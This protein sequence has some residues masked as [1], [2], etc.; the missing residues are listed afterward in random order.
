ML[1]R[2][3]RWNVDKVMLHGVTPEEAEQVVN[4]A[5]NPYPQSG[6]HGRFLVWGPTAAGRFV[7]VVYVPDEVER[8]FVI[9][10]RP[11]TEKEKRRWQRQRRKRGTR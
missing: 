10:A 5:T 2:W 4:G 9:H 7:L 1:Y 6:G 3:T 11:L 8:A